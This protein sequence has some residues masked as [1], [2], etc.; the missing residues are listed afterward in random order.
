[1]T[2]NDVSEPNFTTV[3]ADQDRFCRWV[4]TVN[5]SDVGGANVDVLVT[6]EPDGSVSVATRPTSCP[7]FSWSPPFRAER[8]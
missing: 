4:A 1:M 8:R 5:H 6:L 3:L 7:Q 2:M